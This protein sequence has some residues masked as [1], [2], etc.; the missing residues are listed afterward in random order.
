MRLNVVGFPQV[1]DAHFIA[2]HRCCTF[3]KFKASKKIPIVTLV[4]LQSGLKWNLQYLQGMPLQSCLA[5]PP[6][7]TA[8]SI[9]IQSFRDNSH[10][11][12]TST[13]VELLRK[14]VLQPW[15]TGGHSGA[16]PDH[17]EAWIFSSISFFS[18]RGQK[19]SE[20]AS[21]PLSHMALK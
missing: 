21:G 14:P 5:P 6:P 18:H 7:T 4:L 10:S 17:L 11:R 15:L 2:L 19:L 20:L 16:P 13:G 12:R 3:Y 1:S 9:R 8:A